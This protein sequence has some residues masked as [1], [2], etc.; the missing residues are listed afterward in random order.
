MNNLMVDRC[1]S[2]YWIIDWF[3]TDV[4]LCRVVEETRVQILSL[5]IN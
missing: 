1:Q 4:P 5:D 3:G 2:N